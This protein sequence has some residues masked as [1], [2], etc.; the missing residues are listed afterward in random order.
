MAV[1]LAQE[2]Q[3]DLVELVRFFPIDGVTAFARQ[4][5]ER[6]ATTVRVAGDHGRPVRRVALCSGSGAGLLRE[7]ARAGADV[8]VT[9]DVKYHEARE[10]E[11]LGVALV[12]AGHFATEVIMV[13]ELAQ[14]L[15][16]ELRNRRFAAEV[17]PCRVESDPFT[18]E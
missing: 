11:A 2:A 5:G 7:A 13:E 14:R 18:I 12:D 1:D 10:A 9:G 17:I 15:G 8:L 4:V 3:D 16:Q 6:L